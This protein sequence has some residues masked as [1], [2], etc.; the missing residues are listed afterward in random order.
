LIVSIPAAANTASNAAAN[1]AV[2][3]A[4]EEPELAGTLVEV[5]QQVPGSLGH[6]RPGGMG[7][8]TG[9]VDPTVL[10]FDHKR[11]IQ[12]GQPDGFDGQEVTCQRS[13]GL[14][15]QELRPTRSTAPRRRPEA[16][17]AQDVP[18][19][20]SRDPHAELAALADDAYLPPSGILPGQ[21]QH[22]VDHP[23]I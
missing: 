2:A 11:Y 13:G 17:A 14:G 22:E 19:R 1:L 6:P 12:P 5:H 8:D 15:T 23:G 16:V 21:P 18:H 20:G 3:I 4:D 7:G 10:Q 9:Q